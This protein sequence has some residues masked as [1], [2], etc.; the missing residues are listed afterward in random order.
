MSF[1]IL[2]GFVGLVFAFEYIFKPLVSFLWFV[3]VG[4]VGIWLAVQAAQSLKEYGCVRRQ[5]GYNQPRD[6]DSIIHD[7]PDHPLYT[8]P[9]TDI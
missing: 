2:F 6:E 4:G 8:F 7:D 1:Y 3:G 9:E 5:E